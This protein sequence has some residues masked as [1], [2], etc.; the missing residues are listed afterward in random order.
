VQKVP[1]QEEGGAKSGSTSY[2]VVPPQQALDK[3]DNKPEHK[4]AA[5]PSVLSSQQVH[6]QQPNH[7]KT[8]DGIHRKQLGKN[9]TK[10]PT[11]EG[12]KQEVAEEEEGE[13]LKQKSGEKDVE[14]GNVGTT[15]VLGSRK[16]PVREH[17]DYFE[18]EHHLSVSKLSQNAHAKP[19]KSKS[20]EHIFVKSKDFSCLNIHEKL[21]SV[22]KLS[23]ESGGF[24]LEH[25]TYVQRIAVNS[26]AEGNSAFIKVK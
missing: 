13:A 25:P 18:S 20:S 2:N 6:T 23:R 26:L 15:G 4:K 14:D 8:S 3:K 21:V 5:P 11:S 9:A 10:Q 12:K 1:N 24:G 17:V 22:L 7:N 16:R 19:T